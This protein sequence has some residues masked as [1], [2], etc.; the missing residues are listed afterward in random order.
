M[1]TCKVCKSTKEH[2]YLCLNAQGRSVYVDEAM[3]TWNGKTCYNCFKA[4]IIE[5][6][7]APPLKLVDCEICSLKFKQKHISQT[8]CL[9]HYNTKKKVNKFLSN[10]KLNKPYH[11]ILGCSVV[12]FI[13]K[14]DAD[15]SG[16]GI[17]WYLSYPELTITKYKK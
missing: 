11:E 17:K 6:R 7:G 8:L 16:Y 5:K 1:R 10:L 4:S 15:W 3:G 9:R 14:L 13:K 12:E 2:K